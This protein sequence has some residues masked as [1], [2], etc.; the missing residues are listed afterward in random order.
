M[1]NRRFALA[2]LALLLVV[3]SARHPSANI[4]I[5]A[6]D[7][8]DRTPRQMQAAVDVGVFAV[9]LLVTWTSRPFL[10]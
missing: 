4:S 5:I 1:R 10:R 6:H 3:T 8:A 7:P 2:A 9:S